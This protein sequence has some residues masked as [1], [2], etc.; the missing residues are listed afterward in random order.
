M[1]Y[2]GEGLTGFPITTGRIPRH[3]SAP[4]FSAP[5][6]LQQILAAL[7]RDHPQAGQAPTDLQ[8]PLG[9]LC[10]E[11]DPQL[12]FSD[13]YLLGLDLEHDDP[14]LSQSIFN[15]L[16]NP[17]SDPG[18]RSTSISQQAEHRL[19]ILSGGGSLGEQMEF[20]APRVL[21]EALAPEMLLGMSAGSL[22]FRGV[23]SGSYLGLTALPRATWWNRGRS[24]RWLASTVGFLAEAPTFT[25][26][27]QGLSQVFGNSSPAH[28][29]PLGRQILSGYLMLGSLRL[30]GS[31]MGP[32]SHRFATGQQVFSRFSRAALPQAGMALGLM[33]S[34]GAE[35]AL[36]LRT[37]GPWQGHITEILAT[38]FQFNVAGR[39]AP[40][41]MGHRLRSVEHSL[42]AHWHRSVNQSFD[43]VADSFQRIFAAQN[44]ARLVTPEGMGIPLQVMAM[45]STKGSGGTQMSLG[46][47]STG[48][49]SGSPRSGPRNHRSSTPP[50]QNPTPLPNGR[51]L[52]PRGGAQ[53]EML[54]VLETTTKDT[55]MAREVAQAMAGLLHLNPQSVFHRVKPVLTAQARNQGVALDVYLGRALQH[56]NPTEIEA[57]LSLLRHPRRRE[58]WSSKMDA[59]WILHH[60]LEGGIPLLGRL[61][62]DIG[63]GGSMARKALLRLHGDY[64]KEVSRAVSE[65]LQSDQTLVL[66][67]AL[68]LA[69]KI[70]HP[71]FIPILRS[72][73]GGKR[74]I[75]HR[76]AQAALLRLEDQGLIKK[77][78]AILDNPRSDFSLRAWAAY[79]LGRLGHT[80][81]AKTHLSQLVQ[82]TRT[83][84]RFEAARGLIRLG[85]RGHIPSTLQLIRGMEARDMLI[86]ARDCLGAGYDQQ[87]VVILRQLL[88][89]PDSAFHLQALEVIAQ[90][91]LF[92]LRGEVEQMKS[93][94]YPEN[95]WGATRAQVAF[96]AHEGNKAGLWEM[97][98]PTHRSKPEDPLHLTM[99]R[100]F[101]MN[102]IRL[103]A[104]RALAEMPLETSERARLTQRLRRGLEQNTDP[105]L[106]LETNALLAGPLG[107]SQAQMSLRA[108]LRHADPGIRMRAAEALRSVHPQ[109]DHGI[110]E[111]VA[112]V[113]LAL[114][115][116][117]LRFNSPSLP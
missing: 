63:E 26:T 66:I 52:L 33:G 112:Q 19:E 49:K 117:G 110:L 84:T 27:T 43:S 90:E 50:L 95:R 57:A 42:D 72:L 17:N 40:H 34:Q 97:L 116:T 45:S 67:Q 91:K 104:A 106:L 98:N 105:K 68:T 30:S 37:L 16:G 58:G 77:F 21:E 29:L 107:D 81:R 41:L 24:A 23:R 100:Q 79:G 76:S 113:R 92:D 35:I 111:T 55:P 2:P 78:N 5:Q 94:P 70:P 64:P 80:E 82:S 39:I 87:A 4:D 10:Q 86:L 46:L 31:L 74:R 75:F 54:S 20:M 12:F 61:A 38:L 108:Y 101:A 25:L 44:T 22:A 32:L 51:A 14:H 36:G 8:G 1:V 114:S 60:R 99:R 109:W 102:D 28:S 73:A 13:A 11:T 83:E 65:M 48:P 62:R 47:P 69:T 103:A 96:A 9:H 6:A 115:Q 18:G 15:F 88:R 3:Q 7:P 93:S 59:Q 85:L 89:H 71:S 56:A 53:M